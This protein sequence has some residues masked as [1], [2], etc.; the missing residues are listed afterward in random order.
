MWELIRQA[1]QSFKLG[2]IA[3][4]VCREQQDPRCLHE[5]ERIVRQ[6]TAVPIDAGG[7]VYDR[8]SAVVIFGEDAEDQDLHSVIRTVLQEQ[9]PNSIIRLGTRASGQSGTFAASRGLAIMVWG[10]TEAEEQRRRFELH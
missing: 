1:L 7:S 10:I 2:S 5:L 3:L 4:T 8:I 6:I 9:Y